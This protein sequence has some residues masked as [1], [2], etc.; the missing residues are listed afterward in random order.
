ME[1][2]R[3]KQIL[4]QITRP[5]PEQKDRRQDKK[6]LMQLKKSEQRMRI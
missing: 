3:Q 6:E 1:F 2:E 5:Q 4:Q